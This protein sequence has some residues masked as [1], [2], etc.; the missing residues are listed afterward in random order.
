LK[1][2]PLRYF[3]V[4]AREL[5]EQIGQ[6]VL[7]LDRQ[8]RDP[9][10]VQRLL[11]FAHTLK[12]A[13]RVVKQT[14][15]AAGSHRLEELLVRQTDRAQAPTRDELREL[16]ALVDRMQAEVRHLEAPLKV[17]AS[18]EPEATSD[19]P[20]VSVRVD[21]EELDALLRAVT[22]TNV[23]LA[24]I[25]RELTS[26]TR[27]EAWSALLT[28]LLEPRS[29]EQGAPGKGAVVKARALAGD[30]RAEL[31]RLRQHLGTGL[32]HVESELA[33]AREV[34]ERLRLVPAQTLFPQLERAVFDAAQ[35]LAKEVEF[36]SSGGD[37]RLEAHVLAAL[38]DA[39]LHVVRNAVAH[40][41]ELPNEREC[42]KKPNKGKVSLTVLRQG[43]RAVFRCRDDGRGVDVD[44]TRKAAVERGIV[45]KDAAAA[46]SAAEVTRLLLSA[47]FSTSARVT[48]LSGRGIGLDVAREA[49]E[50]LKG[51]ISIESVPGAGTSVTIVVP[52][53]IASLA[54]LMVEVSGSTLA[55]PLDSVRSSLRLEHG[56]ILRAQGQQSI[57]LEGR[58]VPFLP[59]A[60]LLD[61]STSQ[62]AEREQWSIV[63]LATVDGSAALGVDRVIGI[64]NVVM[65]ALPSAVEADPVIA[66]ATLDA[67]GSPELILDPTALVL[68]VARHR[69]TN[70]LPTRAKQLPIL[71]IDD[72]LTTR[73]LEQSILE[74]AGYRVDLAT[75]AEEG[76][77]KARL[78]R[79]GL[80]I[81]DVE[82]P[83]MTGFEFVATTQAE[84][85]LRE[86]PAILVT[87]RDAPEDRRRGEQA[88]AKAYVVKGEF[89]QGHLLR[90]IRSLMG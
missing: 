60:L 69:G 28:D 11:R 67:E 44:A 62:A 41:L 61:K 68:A 34:T 35:S 22:E 70:A 53:S 20:L 15:L 90:T 10:L 29:G 64:S 18:P 8:P 58:G 16:L 17:P 39:L 57:L 77:E 50:R 81:V 54:A 66:G 72:S 55:I 83:G 42:A 26:L 49:T 78:T 24:A 13:A 19:G 48:E 23:R 36:E 37:V 9:E 86:T 85:G 75:S 21:V 79:Y 33:D 51:S 43:T 74:S 30:L 80:F 63:V 3:R 32:G 7:A 25:R 56:A 47:G 82:M 87:S 40:G 65:R 38:R 59:L 14:A 6:G 46:M 88:G 12:G 4:E 76:L 5:V 84:P 52:V 27:L 71:V 45:T 2:D 73:M 89:E 1:P 31:E